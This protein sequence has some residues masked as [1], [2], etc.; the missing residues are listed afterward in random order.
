MSDIEVLKLLLLF[1]SHEY[2]CAFTYSLQSNR[3]CDCGLEA[4]LQ[5]LRDGDFPIDRIIGEINVS[6]QLDT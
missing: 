5:R 6:K 3:P 2:D 1:V 4:A